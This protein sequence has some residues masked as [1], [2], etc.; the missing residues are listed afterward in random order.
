[1]SIAAR[2]RSRQPVQ[3]E[4]PPTSGPRR[5][6][7]LKV[8]VVLA[9]W[10][11]GWLLLRGRMTLALGGA[12]VTGFHTWLDSVRD[13]VENARTGNFLFDTILGNVSAALSWVV[14]TLQHL[15][16]TA[17]FPR[18]VPEIGWLG[19]LAILAWLAFAVAGWRAA[20]LVTASVLPSGCSVSGRTA[21]T[22]S[23][24]PPSPSPAAPS[25]ASPSGSPWPVA[26]G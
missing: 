13:W 12:E 25:S 15:L 24:S 20:A 11:V 14:T 17:A 2:Q 22:F 3:L 6:T 21:S 16:S 7:P 5:R 9:V 4:E 26:H 10:V 8:G 23:S 1:M 18:P 19:V